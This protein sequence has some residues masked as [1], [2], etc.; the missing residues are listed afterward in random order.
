MADISGS[1]ALHLRSISNLK[2]E[3]A[4]DPERASAPRLNVIANRHV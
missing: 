4:A 1:A 3:L 2:V